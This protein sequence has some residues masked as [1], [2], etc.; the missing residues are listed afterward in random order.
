MPNPWHSFTANP[1][2]VESALRVRYD[3]RSMALMLR[4]RVSM[5]RQ[6]WKRSVAESDMN[7]R[8][9]ENQRHVRQRRTER[10][11]VARTARDTASE[12]HKK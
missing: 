7:G 5:R 3:G 1:S 10:H 2:L 9:T 12:T 11:N 6:Q 4:E 8:Q